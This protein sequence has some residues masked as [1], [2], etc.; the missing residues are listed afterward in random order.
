MNKEHI[1]ELTEFAMAYYNGDVVE[2]MPVFNDDELDAL[3][4]GID[5]LGQELHEQVSS[6]DY[7]ST[8]FRQSSQFI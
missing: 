3:A 6:K 2:S 7:F 8:L 4:L 1:H 5:L